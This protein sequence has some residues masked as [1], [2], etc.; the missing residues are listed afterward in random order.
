MLV[1]LSD[2]ALREINRKTLSSEGAEEEGSSESGSS[3][4]SRHPLNTNSRDS[5]SDVYLNIYKQQEPLPNPPFLQEYTLELYSGSTRLDSSQ[6]SSSGPGEE[7]DHFEI[8]LVSQTTFISCF[9][10]MSRIDRLFFIPHLLSRWNGFGLPDCFMGRPVSITVFLDKSSLYVA[11]SFIMASS[12]P[13]RLM[14]TLY[15][16]TNRAG[17]C[18]YF[19]QLSGGVSCKRQPIYP[20]NRLRNLSIKRVETSHFIMLDMDAWPSCPLLSSS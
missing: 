12:F 4:Y 20:I 15:V 7:S 19:R 13:S 9:P 11:R 14:L 6:A 16:P 2:Y 5:Y 8:T 17:D 1:L 3:E 18:I 10:V